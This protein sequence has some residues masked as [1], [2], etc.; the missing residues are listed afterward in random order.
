VTNI[1]QDKDADLKVLKGETIAIIGYGNQGRSQALNMRD[2]G[3]KV[4]VGNISDASL[5][6]A[7]AD[8]F[9]S[10]SI[11]E[12]SEKASIILL[13]LPDEVQPKVY[14]AEIKPAMKKGKALVF[15][16]GYN[17]H[18]GFLKPQEDI[19]VLL[20]APRMV[21]KFVREL[22][23][24]GTGAPVFFCVHQDA[25]GKAMKRV[26]ALAKGI[27]ATRV[28]AMEVNVG[29]ETELDHFSEHW[30]APMISRVLILGYEVLTEM[31]Y[32]KDAVLMETYMSGELG[33]V[34]SSLAK[35]GLVVQLPFHS[36]TSQFGQLLYADRVMP[37]DAKELIRELVMEIKLG[38]FAKEWQLE[39]ILGYPVFNK[40]MEQAKAHPINKAEAELKERV[41]VVID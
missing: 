28:G 23:E 8:G 19:D 22:Y 12:A 27:G 20:L 24:K 31:G 4:I 3:L 39:Q 5:E 13:L 6:R 9:E 18:Y 14:E 21:G 25:S 36:R 29:D 35:D 40:L 32:D 34:C 37:E 30:I 33:E 38:T 15:A 2:S 17:L 7:K 10:Y 16:H 26:L 41:K 1:Y 11:K